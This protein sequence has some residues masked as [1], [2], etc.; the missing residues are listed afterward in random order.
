MKISSGIFGIRGIVV[1]AILV[2]LKVYFF[3]HFSR[4]SNTNEYSRLYL[5]EA[6][7][8]DHTLC[9]NKAIKR[10]RAIMDKSR[11]GDCLL[12]DKAPGMAFGGICAY[13]PVYELLGPLNISRLLFL[14]RTGVSL[15]P[16]LV[17][18]IM[19]AAVLRRMTGSETL[20]LAGTAFYILGTPACTYSTMYFA[21]QLSAVCVFTSFYIATHEKG[22]GKTGSALW[23]LFLGLAFAVEYQSFI[24]FI[25]TFA[26]LI[27]RSPKRLTTLL[28][29]SAGAAVFAF[30]TLYYNYAAFGH[31]FQTG[32]HHLVAR[33][34]RQVHEQGFLGFTWPP[35]MQNLFISFLSTS[36][37]VF[38]FSPFLL[39]AIPGIFML[40]KRRFRRDGGSVIVSEIFL[41][42]LFISL[43]V[44]C[45]GGWSVSQRHLTPLAP[46]LMIPAVVFMGRL[47]KSARI[48][49]VDIAWGLGFCSVFYTYVSTVVFPH[50]PEVY[51]NPFYQLALPLIREG[52]APYSIGRL[53][54]LEGF[55][56]YLP[57]F[58][59]A[60]GLLFYLALRGLRP[61]HIARRIFIM[62]V[63]LTLAV[64][65]FYNVH[66][67][68]NRQESWH[69]NFVRKI[70]EPGLE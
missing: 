37:G 52:Y 8:I 1:F 32:Y 27:Y 49:V 21:H 34:F 64:A 56:S 18:L 4:M 59:L 23:G 68:H 31:P 17:M 69:D 10:H 14:L 33:H 11:V 12:S 66:T 6:V 42:T 61:V 36:K 13:W 41:Y 24:F 19:F 47:E 22:A 20:A 9:I 28:A 44:Y 62:A 16:T 58:V 60:A 39:L 26:L 15:L 45:I 54:G 3:P 55:Y 40:L 67:K 43:M 50:F 29:V 65:P 2:L 5:V 53:L 51:R 48:P 35:K 63:V 7:V 46:F 25:P 38:F 70:Y 30:I 57:A